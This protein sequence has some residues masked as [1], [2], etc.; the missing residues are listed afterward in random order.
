[1]H[2]LMIS[3]RKAASDTDPVI[4]T[5]ARLIQSRRPPKLLKEVSVCTRRDEPYHAGKM[6]MQ[7]CRAR[8]SDLSGEFEIPLAQFVLCD[9]EPLTVGEAQK[10]LTTE[11]YGGL[12]EEEVRDITS[13]EEEK[14]IKIFEGDEIEPKSLMK[15]DRSLVTKNADYSFQMFRLYVIYEG[16]DKD[17]VIAG[18]HNKVKDWDKA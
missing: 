9:T 4:R 16:K 13:E 7:N 6:F 2:L 15:I 17:D 12:T 8:L 18:L 10:K 11:E 14:D 5:M 1:M 3:I